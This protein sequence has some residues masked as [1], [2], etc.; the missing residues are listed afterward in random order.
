MGWINNECNGDSVP[1]GWRSWG[2][3]VSGV[4][5]QTIHLNNQGDE[6]NDIAG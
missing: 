6:R 2:S 5:C 1:V 4:K 3:P